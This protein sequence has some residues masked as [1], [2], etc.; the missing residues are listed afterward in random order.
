MSIARTTE[1]IAAG[2]SV[3]EAINNGI[4]R[5]TETLKNVEEVW[6]QSVKARVQDGRISEYRVT[7]KVTFVLE[8]T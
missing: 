7:M 5:A 4:D 3:E 2:S 6:V 1:I 8:G